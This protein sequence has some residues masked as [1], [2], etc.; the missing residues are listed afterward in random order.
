[1]KKLVKPIKKSQKSTLAVK[2]YGGSKKDECKVSNCY[3]C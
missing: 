2:L 3:K 1:M